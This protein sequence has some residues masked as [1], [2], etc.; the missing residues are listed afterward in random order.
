MCPF[1][2]FVA[3]RTSVIVPFGN[4]EHRPQ[5]YPRDSIHL[6][7]RKIGTKP[8]KHPRAKDPFA[9]LPHLCGIKR[10]IC[11]FK[12]GA[13][14]SG[15]NR[16]NTS[17][18]ATSTGIEPSTAVVS[19]S[20][21]SIFENSKARE[22]NHPLEMVRWLTTSE[23]AQYLRVSI[24]SIKTMIYRGQVRVHKLGRRNRFLRD[25]LERLITLPC[26]N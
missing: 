9:Q 6:R 8:A 11:M 7:S 22:Q 13:H 17:G 14:K 20:T 4:S 12:R 2:N 5:S 16:Q 10:S 3:I 18:S 15:G 26:T 25:E 21:N 24:S 1:G 23:A 19:Q